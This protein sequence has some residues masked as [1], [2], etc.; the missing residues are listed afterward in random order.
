VAA[1]R[2]WNEDLGQAIAIGATTGMIDAFTDHYGD[3]LVERAMT[4][5]SAADD[6]DGWRRPGV[7]DDVDGLRRLSA[8][9]WDESLIRQ[10]TDRVKKL[11]PDDATERARHSLAHYDEELA[12]RQL[13]RGGPDFDRQRVLEELRSGTLH[14]RR[15][16]D[17]IEQRKIGVHMLGE[18]EF[19]YRFRQLSGQDPDSLELGFRHGEQIYLRA[20]KLSPDDISVKVVHEATH[21]LDVE[22]VTL[23]DREMQAFLREAE[24]AES[25]GLPSEALEILRSRGYSGLEASVRNAY[26]RPLKPDLDILRERMAQFGY[27]EAVIERFVLDVEMR[28]LHRRIVRWEETYLPGILDNPEG[29]RRFLLTA[30]LPEGKIERYFLYLEGLKRTGRVKRTGDEPFSNF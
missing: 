29:L 1:G 14:S 9:E 11:L 8:E 17:L 27:P 2:P 10:P 15:I 20:N 7:A 3:M 23:L 12:A 18:D 6:A 4:P 26:I 13:A 19:A 5:R 28:E 21:I 16:A 24:F 30:E 22:N 25:L